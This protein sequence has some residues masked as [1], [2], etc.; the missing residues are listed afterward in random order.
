VVQ[1]IKEKFGGLRFYYTGGDD[2]IS[3]MVEVAE[4]WASRV[5]EECG[6]PATKQTSGWI[7][8]VCDKHYDEIENRKREY[9][10]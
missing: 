10:S 1:Q 9:E 6:S 8:T 4:E 3:G 2:K 7:K 5:C